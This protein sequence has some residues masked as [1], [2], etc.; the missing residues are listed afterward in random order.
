MKGVTIH[1]ASKTP[2]SLR[3]P[4]AFIVQAKMAFAQLQQ[5]VIALFLST[6]IALC[7]AAQERELFCALEAMHHSV[8]TDGARPTS[9][10]KQPKQ[11]GKR[12]KHQSYISFFMC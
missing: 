10:S 7:F 3:L 6:W 4:V 9:K 5:P 1:T 8:S 12:D 2:L 11:V